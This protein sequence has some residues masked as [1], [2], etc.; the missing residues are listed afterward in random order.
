MLWKLYDNEAHSLIDGF[1]EVAPKHDKLSIATGYWDL[2][3]MPTVLPHLR[4]YQE[5]RLLIGMEPTPGI[6]RAD[7]MRTDFPDF[8]FANDLE[9]L[10][11]DPNLG[12]A[13]SEMIRLM[14]SGI[15]K[16]RKF[17][18]TFLHVS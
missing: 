8:D 17:T 5:I 3:L 11:Y 18:K 1:T 4:H 12:Q 13:A 9:A 15:L 2:N 6:R 7:G 14:E 16:V 10:V